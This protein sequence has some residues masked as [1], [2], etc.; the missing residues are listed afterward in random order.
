MKV[1]FITLLSLSLVLSVF[2][3]SNK[4]KP[5]DKQIMHYLY[6]AE[7]PKADSLLDLQI[8]KDPNHPKYYMLK[9]HF[10][11][12]TRYFHDGALSGDSLMQ[13]VYDYSSKAIELGEEMEETTEI[14]FYLGSAY[15]F[16]SRAQLRLDGR[17][18]AYWSAR[19]CMNY[20]EDVI[21]EDPTYYD[22]Y[23][24][25]GVIEYFTGLQ[26][27]GFYNFLVWFVGMSGDRELGMEYFHKVADNGELFKT[28]A[29]F[30]IGAM[31]TFVENDHQQAYTVFTDLHEKYPNNNF[32]TNQLDRTYF[33][34][35]VDDRGT[36]FLTTERDSLQSKYNIT[37]ANILN[38]LGYNLMNQGRMDDALVVFKVNIELFPDIANCYDSIAEYYMNREENDLS[39]RYYNIAYEKLPA[40]STVNEQ[41][42]ERLR[43]GIAQKLDD[44][45][46]P[47]DI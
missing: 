30:A 31:S 32:I 35:L 34:K 3:G 16:L 4:I 21:E 7:W 6:N 19:D 10:H 25:I 41:F 43:E 20:L 29:K 38:I 42:K 45:G 46:A 39:I 9:A 5:V 23:M 12:Y 26:F 13:L 2:A 24:G 47:L 15:G 28:E 14:K 37:N 8:Q 44:L 36:D 33:L 18:N 40:D 27:T 17:W 1:F 22:A 11:Y